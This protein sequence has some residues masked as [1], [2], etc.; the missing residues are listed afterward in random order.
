MPSKPAIACRGSSHDTC[1][2]KSPDPA[3]AAAFAMFWAR[4]LSSSCRR[5][6]AGGETTRD[7][8]AQPGVVRRI[9][10]QHDEALDVDV[11]TRDVVLE[12]GDHPFS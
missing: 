8:L 4:S 5:P 6:I 2:T 11:L 1:S 3:A 12:P 10:V 7:D 9:H